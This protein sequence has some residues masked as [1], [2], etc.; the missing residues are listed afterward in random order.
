M[1]TNLTCPCCGYKWTIKY[2]KWIFT[3]LFHIFNFFSW[4]DY[5]Y[6]RC[7][8]CGEKSWIAREK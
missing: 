8:K 4:K 3:T 1:K 2:C 7:P 6:T 5:R